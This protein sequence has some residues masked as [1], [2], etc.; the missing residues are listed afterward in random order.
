MHHIPQ[1][2]DSAIQLWQTEKMLRK[3]RIGDW[4]LGL[5]Q[6][7]NIV[8]HNDD[9]ILYQYNSIMAMSFIR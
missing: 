7:T 1:W 2:T 5:Y 6:S 9:K 8:Y 3:T 4:E